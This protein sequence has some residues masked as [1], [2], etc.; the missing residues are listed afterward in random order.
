MAINT[1]KL[2][3]SSGGGLVKKSININIA[4]IANI[5][6]IGGDNTGIGEELNVIKEKLENVG[7]LLKGTLADEKKRLTDEKNKDKKEKRE[8]GEEKVEKDDDK[9]KD[10]KKGK[11]NLPKVPGFGIGNFLL[12]VGLGWIVLKIIEL[13]PIMMPFLSGLAKVGDGLIDVSG[14]LLSGFATVISGVM[15]AKESSREWIDGTLGEDAAKTFDE[16]S[17]HLETFLNAV[18]IAAMLSSGG[19][20]GKGLGKKAARE[21]AEKVGRGAIRRKGPKVEEG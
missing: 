21:A 18:F 3:P 10:G 20:G 15:G 9:D 12:N 6:N 16:F 1:Q 17:G 5:G 11:L 4:K 7:N 19:R 8:K 2:L 14:K 13:G